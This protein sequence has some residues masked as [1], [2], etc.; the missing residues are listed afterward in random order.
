VWFAL[1]L[2]VVAGCGRVHFDVDGGGGAP[3]YYA[4]SGDG[5]S[6]TDL[7]TLDL[8]TAH[9]TVVGTIPASLGIL[10]GLAYWDANTL[11]ATSTGRVVAITLSPFSAVVTRMI[12]GTYSSLERDGAQLLGIDQDAETIASFD[13]NGSGNVVG[14]QLGL[15]AYGGDLTRRGGVWYWY[16]NPTNQL[17]IVSA[18]ADP[19]PFGAPSPSVPFVAGI[20]SDD[21]GRMFFITDGTDELIEIDA[22]SGQPIGSMIVDHDLKSGDMTRSP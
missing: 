1:A 21:T 3:T 6:P 17:Y 9:A 13:P 8:E 4:V 18:T 11:Y 19:V 7:L 2:V 15:D 12:A 20:V 22:S 14:R 10:G 5:V 16:A